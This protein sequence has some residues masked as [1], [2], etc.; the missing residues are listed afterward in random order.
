MCVCDDSGD[1]EYFR[2]CEKDVY[3]NIELSVWLR[4]HT[5]QANTAIRKKTKKKKLLKEK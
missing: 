1:G 5:T 3:F 2:K 4:K